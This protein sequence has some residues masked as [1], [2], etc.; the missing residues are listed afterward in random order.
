MARFVKFSDDAHIPSKAT[1]ASVGLDLRVTEETKLKQGI[2][3]IDVGIGVIPPYGHYAQ[4]LS[5]S[6]LAKKGITTL[7]G[8]IDPD[9]RGSI[10]AI[11]HCEIPDYTLPEGDA[12]S[13]LVFLHYYIGPAPVE[14]T[15]DEFNLA[16]TVRGSRG[17]G[18]SSTLPPADI[19]LV[20]PEPFPFPM[21]VSQLDETMV[22]K[23]VKH[24]ETE[25]DNEEVK[26]KSKVVCKV[27]HDGHCDED[28]EE[29]DSSVLNLVTKVKRQRS[30]S[31]PPA[32]DEDS[33]DEKASYFSNPCEYATK[34]KDNT[35][36]PQDAFVH[37][38]WIDNQARYLEHNKSA[39]PCYCDTCK[40]YRT[41]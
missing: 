29:C 1:P 26:R 10:R 16:G 18:S 31:E 37:G 34:E 13:Q 36:P 12:I 19:D 4:L 41:P 30:D 35:K 20:K 33:D 39:Y 21:N 9:Y 27:I 7:G 15:I 28:C 38:K 6:G 24:A 8:V 22:R 14:I 25:R 11:I 32:D 40:L 17:F 2:N 5:R 3:F 23:L